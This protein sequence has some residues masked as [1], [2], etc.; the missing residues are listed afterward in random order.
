VILADVTSTNEVMCIACADLYQL[1]KAKCNPC[2][3]CVLT[4]YQCVNA[5]WHKVGPICQLILWYGGADN[6]EVDQ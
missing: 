5:T 2:V 6:S 3:P 4:W 1:D